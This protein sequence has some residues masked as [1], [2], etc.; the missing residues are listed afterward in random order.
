MVCSQIAA[1]QGTD[2]NAIRLEKGRSLQALLDGFRSRGL[3]SEG[4]TQRHLYAT[5]WHALDALTADGLGVIVLGGC[6]QV[7]R[8]LMISKR[9][10]GKW[11]LAMA[12]QRASRAL[13]PL[14][15]LEEVLALAQV[16]ARTELVP[17]VWLLTPQANPTAQPARMGSWGL[18]RTARMEGSLTLRCMDASVTTAFSC[19]PDVETEAVCHRHRRLVPRLKIAPP[20]ADGFVQHFGG[21]HIVTGGTGGLGLLTGRWLAACG[22]R[23]LVLASRSGE[24]GSNTVGEMQILQASEGTQMR[25]E[26]CDSG[27][28]AH[29]IRL[30]R[31]S[32]LNGSCFHGVWHAAGVIADGVLSK[33]DILALAHVYTAK[34]HGSWNLHAACTA[35]NLRVFALFSSVAALLGTV[36]QA[37]YAA[38]NACLDALAPYRRMRSAVATSVQ[39]GAWA[40]VGMA[41]RGA[42]SE[43][44]TVLEAASGFARIKLAQGLRVLGT[45]VRLGASPVLALVPVTWSRILGSGEESPAFL[46]AFQRRRAGADVVQGATAAQTILSLE[47]VLEMVRHTAGKE[48]NADAPLM[49]SGVDSLGAVELRNQ[50]QTA[51]G[52]SLPSTLVFDF[53]S[54]RQVALHIQNS[55]LVAP[56]FEPVTTAPALG[57]HLDTQNNVDITG[58]NIE[59]AAGVGCLRSLRAKSA[60]GLDLLGQIPA[61]RWDAKQAA[62]SMRGLPPEVSSRMRHAGFLVNAELF[63]QNFY[64][65]SKAEA[66]AMDPQQRQLLER[67]YVA[68]H[69]GGST[70]STLLGSV[71]A[72]NVGQWASEFGSVLVRTPAGRSVYASTGYT[73]SVTCGRVSFA[74]GMQGPCCSFD[75]ACSASLVAN[76]SSM[77]ALQKM[78]C[79]EALSAGVNMITDPATMGYNAIA[80]FTSITGRSHTFDARAD[81]Y[82]R[83]EAVGAMVCTLLAASQV[84]VVG[85]AIRQDGRSASLTAPNGQAQQGVLK[86][87]YTDASQQATKVAM[88]EAHG[89]GTALGDPIE[90]GAVAAV[91]LSLRTDQ[92]ASL[93]TGSLKANA[94]HCEPGAGLA[95]ASKLIVHLN[96]LAVPPNA[97]LRVLNPH[98]GG[99]L[100]GLACA[101]PTQATALQNVPL[102]GGVSSFGYAGTIAHVVI[103]TSSDGEMAA[104]ARE[105][106]PMA[107]AIMDVEMRDPYYRRRFSWSDVP[108]PFLMQPSSTDGATVFQ[109]TAGLLHELVADHA[110]QGR[111]IFPAAGYLELSRAAT[112]SALRGVFFLQPLTVEAPDLLVECAV[113]DAR[114]EV[115]SGEGETQAIHCS[116]AL[117]MFNGWSR[118]EQASMRVRSCS[119]A[120]CTGALYDK[121]D[122]VGLQY[123]PGYRTL[124][125]AWVG[126]SGAA[127]ARL[128]ERWTRNGALVHP[129]DLDDALKI[130]VAVAASGGGTSLPF[131]VDNARLQGTHGVLWAV[132]HT[133]H[134]ARAILLPRMAERSLR[135]GSQ[136]VARESMEAVSVR[137]GALLAP[138]AQLDDFKTRALRLEAPTQ[139]HLY[140]TE[141]RTLDATDGIA[142]SPMLMIS[143]DLAGITG[144]RRVVGRERLESGLVASLAVVAQRVSPVPLSTLEVALALAQ[145]QAALAYA[146][147]VWLLTR[148][149]PP[150]ESAMHAGSWG[151]MRAVRAEASLPLCCSVATTLSAFKRCASLTEP[152]VV[153][154]VRG[155][156]TPRLQTAAPTLSGLM[157]LHFHSRGAISNLFLESLPPPTSLREAEVRLEVRAVG[158]NFRDVLNVLGEYP[159]DPG[160]P[161]GDA[162]GFVSEVEFSTGLHAIGDTVFGLAHAPLASLA[163][164]AAP[165]LARKPSVLVLQAACTLPVTWSTTHM[166]LERAGLRAGRSIIVQAAVGGVGLKA[167]EYAQWLSAVAVGTAGR[168]HKHAPLRMSGV[169]ALGSSRNGAAFAAGITGLLKASRSHALL[170]SLSLDFIAA[171]FAALGEGGAFGE[172]GKR[173]IWASQRR[174]AAAAH[175]TYCAI[176]LDAD[177]AQ[178][179]M[180]MHGV[181]QKLAVRADTS[182][183]TSLP[184][185]SFDM[186]VQHELAF[187]TLQGGL[188]TGKIVV[189]VAKYRPAGAS[190]GHVV[191]GGT[192][193]LGLLTARWIG[194]CGAKQLSL[195]SRSGALA[196]G[197]SSEWSVLANVADV[198]LQQ[199]DTSEDAHVRRLV[200]KT[201]ATLTGVWHAAGVLAD[202]MLPKQDARSLAVVH[203]PKAHGVQSLHGAYSAI[204]LR[205][206]V[207][208][209]SVTALLGGSGQANYSAANA[210]LDALASH[211]RMHSAAAVSVQ[212]GAWAEMGMAARGAASER[213]AAMEAASG[214]ARIGLAQ[215]L[216]ALDV[217]T[218]HKSPMVL[219][220]VPISWTRFLGGSTAVPAF[221]LTFAPPK[222][223]EA[224]AVRDGLSSASCVV[225]LESV[226]EMVQR[227]AGGAVDADAPLM[228]SGVD[229]LGAVELRNQL[230]G[231]AG[232]SLPSTLVFDH[233]TARQLG[234]VVQPEQGTPSVGMKAPSLGSALSAAAADVAIGGLTALVAAGASSARMASN[235]VACGSDMITEVPATRW[236]LHPHPGLPEPIASRIRH[237]GFVRDAELVDNAAFATSPAEA[238][239]MDPCQ[240]LLLERSY[241]ALHDA[242]LD[243][244]ALTGSLVGVFL[245]YAATE[246]GSIIA[247]SP[248]GGSVYAAT[249]ASVSIA[250]GRLSYALGLH[251]PC[252]S[253]DTACSAA[254]TASHAALRA[255]QLD[256][257]ASCL[258]MGATLFFAPAISTA[259]AV[260]GMTSAQGRSRTFDARADGYARGEACGGVAL[261]GDGESHSVSL[262]GA[263]VRQDGRSASLT[264][265][266]GQAQQGVLVAALE[267]AQTSV[268]MLAQNEA[269][270]TGTKLGD[271][272]EASSLMGAVLSSRDEPL[273]VG[274]VKANIGHAEPAAGM[275]GLLKLALGLRHGDAGP[276]AHLRVRNP[277]V[278]DALSEAPVILQNQLTSSAADSRAGGVSS[279]GYSG[280][281]VHVLMSERGGLSHAKTE[282]EIAIPR[283]ALC[284]RRRLF[285]WRDHESDQSSVNVQYSST[286][287]PLSD[288]TVPAAKCLVLHTATPVHQPSK[289]KAPSVTSKNHADLCIIGGGL[290]GFIIARDSASCGFSSIVLEMED[291]I[292]GVWAKNDYPGL[293]LQHSGAAYRC[294]SLA[295]TWQREGQGRE[296][297]LYAPRA[298]EILTY[299]K[300]M[301]EHELIAVRL[302][303]AYQSHH[304]SSQHLY[305]V[306]TNKAPV[307]ARGVVIATG[308]NETT[309]GS[310][311]WPI[312]RS[313]ITNGAFVMHSSGLTQG[314][315]SFDTATTKY[316]VGSSKAAIDALEWMDPEDE[317]LV[318][319]HRGH[320]IFHNRNWIDSIWKS[321]EPF[322]P[323]EVSRLL[324][325][326]HYLK[327]QQFDAAFGGMLK[328]GIAI[329][330]GL[331]L[332]T[333]PWLRGGFESNDSL[334]HARRFLPRQVIIS[335]L[336]IHEGV[337][338][339]CCSDGRVISVG[340]TDAVIMCTGQRSKSG[341]EASYK[342]RAELNKDGVFHVYA[343]HR[344]L[345]VQNVL[346]PSRHA[347]P[348]LSTVCARRCTFSNISPTSG[349]YM[350]FCVVSFL[351]GTPT[352]YTDGRLAAALEKVAKHMEVVRDRTAWGRFW[353]EQ[354]AT[355]MDAAPLLLDHAKIE[356]ASLEQHYRWFGE[357]YG[358]DLN[359]ESVFSLF[360]TEQNPESALPAADSSTVL[361]LD[362]ARGMDGS[363]G[364]VHAMVCLA[365]ALTS[366][367]TPTQ[368]LVLTCGAQSPVPAAAG[369]GVGGVAHSGVWG[370]ARTLRLELPGLR[371]RNADVMGRNAALTVSV[372]ASE[373]E[374]EV[375]CANGTCHAARLCHHGMDITHSSS[376]LGGTWMLTG[377]LGGLSLRAAALLAT[378]NASR[379]VL[380]SRSGRVVREGQ[381]LA[382][383]LRDLGLTAVLV[384]CDS[385]DPVQST[386]M[387][388]ST[389]ARGVLHAAGLTDDQLILQ[390][391]TSAVATVFASKAQAAARL[392]D[393]SAQTAIDAL[394]L[395]SSFAAMFGGLGVGNYAA[396]N[397]VLDSLAMSRQ[398]RGLTACSLQPLNVS[399][400]GM[401]QALNDVGK[402]ARSWSL[403][404][405][406][407]AT[408]L[409]GLLAGG[410]GVHLPLPRDMARM[411]AEGDASTW[412]Q[413]MAQSRMTEVAP[414]GVASAP[415]TVAE[416]ASMTLATT[417]WRHHAASIV[418]RELRELVGSTATF[419]VDTTLMDAGL[420][421]LGATE[422]SSRLRELTG[423]ELSPTI[424]FEQPTPRAVVTHLLEQVGTVAVMESV[425]PA[426]IRVTAAGS[427]LSLAGLAGRWPG[428]CN[429]DTTRW[430][431]QGSCGNAMGR[432]PRTRWVLEETVDVNVLSASQASC[433]RH[434]GF[435]AGSQCFDARAFGIS[436]AEASAMDPQQRLLLE[437]GYASL[438]GSSHRRM[439]LM[440]G[441][442]GVLLGIERPDWALAQPPSARGS[443]F[444]ATGDNVSAAAGRVSFVLGLQGPCS[445]VDTACSSSLVAVHW[446]SHA[447]TC[448][449]CA[450]VLTLA[451]GLKLVP[452]F[453][454]GAAAAGMLSMDGR[455]KTLDAGANGYA[456][457]EAVG[458]FLLLQDSRALQLSGSAVRQDG[459]SAS[460]TAPNGS[461]Q[462]TLLSTAHTRTGIEPANLGRVELHGTGTALGDPTEAGSLGGVHGQRTTPLVVGA[463]KA[464]LGHSEAPSGQVGLL[465]VWQAIIAKATSANAKLRSI[466]PLIRE[467]LGLRSEWFVLST[468]GATSTSASGLSAFGYSGTIAYTVL[469]PT[470]DDAILLPSPRY[471]RQAFAW[472]DDAY[473]ATEPM[474]LPPGPTSKKETRHWHYRIS[475]SCV[476]D[477]F[478]TSPKG[479]TLLAVGGGP[480]IFSSWGDTV[481]Q[482]PEVAKG[483]LEG[484][485][486]HAVILTASLQ[487]DA[488]ANLAE[489]RVVDTALRLLQEQAALHTA[490]PV[491]LATRATQPLSQ[492]VA[493]SHSGLW[494]LAR[495]CRLEHMTLPAWCVDVR[496]DERC[497]NAVIRQ[498]TL[499]LPHGS[500]QALQLSASVEPEAACASDTLY[501]PRLV[502]PPRE[503][504]ATLEIAFMMVCSLLDTHTSRATS[505]LDMVRL[506]RAYALLETLCQQYLR[507][508]LDALS[509]SEVP[510]WHH[511]LV[512]AWCSNV[513]QLSPSEPTIAPADV[514][515]AHSDL[516]AEVHL[517][518]RC[519]S[520]FADA[521]SGT[522]AYQ[523]LLF[524]GGSMEAV[525]PVYEKAVGQSF[526]NTCV[527]AAVEAVLVLTGERR[528]VMLEVGAGTG[529]TASSILPVVKSVCDRYV[530]TDVSKAFMR[531]ARARFADF[532]FLECALL[533]IDADP[534]LQGFAPHEHDVIIST[535]CLHATPF[536]R[537]TL[538]NCAELLCAGG[539]IIVNEVLATASFAQMTFGMTDGW[540]LFAEV[541]DPE[542]IGQ[543]S[544]LLSWR[545]WEAL[546]IANGFCNACSIQGDTFL[547]NQAVMLAQTFAPAGNETLMAFGDGAHFLSGGLGGLG[548]LTARLLVEQGALQIFLSSGSNRVVAGSEAD[549]AWLAACDAD[550]R[551]VECDAAD[552]GSVRAV[553]RRLRGDGLL[554]LDGVFNTAHAL[555]EAALA[556]QHVLNFRSTYGPKVHSATAMHNTFM[557]A[558]L[559][560][561]NLFSSSAGLMGSPGQASHSA[562]TAWAITMA[563]RRSQIG[564]CGSSSAVDTDAFGG[565][566]WS[567][568]PMHVTNLRG[569]LHMQAAFTLTLDTPIDFFWA[570]HGMFTPWTANGCSKDV[571]PMT[572]TTSKEQLTSSTVA[573]C[574]GGAQVLQKVLQIAQTMTSG[575]LDADMPLVDAGID[576]ISAVELRNQVSVLSSEPALP[577]TLVF[578]HPTARGLSLFLSGESDRPE[579]SIVPGA[580]SYEGNSSVLRGA[581]A[582]LPNN[583]L[584]NTAIW[585]LAAASYDAISEV[586]FHRKWE[587]HL[588]EDEVRTRMQYAGFLVTTELFDNC[589]FAVSLVETR[590]MD[591]S[592]RLLLD[593]G[594]TALHSSGLCRSSLMDSVT[595]VFV[596]IS[597]SHFLDCLDMS[598][599]SGVYIGSGSALAIASGRLS[600]VLGMQ[601][602]CVSLDT[603]CSGGLVACHGALSALKFSE[604]PTALAGGVNMMLTPSASHVFAVAGMTSPHG[605]CHTFDQRADGYTRAEACSTAALSNG[606]DG[607]SQC[608]LRGSAVRQDG[609]SASLTAPNGQAQRTLINVTTSAAGLSPSD[610]SCVEAHGTGTAL[611]DP[612]EMGAIAASLCASN[613]HQIA[614]SSIKSNV[615]HTE[616]AAGLTG[617]LKL[618]VLEARREVASNAQLRAL[619]RHVT[620][621]LQRARCSLPVQHSRSLADE[622]ATGGVS[623][624]GWSGTIA[625]LLV[626]TT[627]KN[628]SSCELTCASMTMPSHIVEFHRRLA[629]WQRPV[630]P[631]LQSRH[632]TTPDDVVV[633]FSSPARGGLT[634]VV[635]D[636]VILGQTTFPAAGYIEMAC[637]CVA[638]ASQKTRELASVRNLFFLQPLQ[639]SAASDVDVTCT[640]RTDGVVQI[641]S[642][643]AGSGDA[644]THCSGEQDSEQQVS[645]LPDLI[646]SRG[647]SA[648]P[649]DVEAF[650]YVFHFA[651]SNYGPAFQALDHIWTADNATRESLACLKPRITRQG[652]C[653]HP[654]DLDGALQLASW[655]AA[656]SGSAQG[657]AR[658]PFAV[659]AATLHSSSATR[660]LTVCMSFCDGSHACSRATR[661]LTQWC[662]PLLAGCGAP[663]R[664]CN[665]G[666]IGCVR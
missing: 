175:T 219:G 12:T 216:A 94:G 39:W 442:S 653:V 248:A 407:Y 137:L 460:L 276:N 70:K 458:A 621:P 333:Q 221:L 370:L 466:N 188:N 62:H 524:P 596:A 533:N 550:V 411:A 575:S 154:H 283:K 658:L 475:W 537:N 73:C 503:Q 558:S 120:A 582:C 441:D 298:R 41:A 40:E 566:V 341:G 20:P 29:V 367:K 281:I 579:L 38:A 440:S 570:R 519:G 84:C 424:V 284:F 14:I 225:S 186:E 285:F 437:F 525:L 473:I 170:N 10:T 571:T 625:H 584:S 168:P 177:M 162:A 87:A 233:P 25:I 65:I 183:I 292:G 53:P 5:E 605:R 295:P 127:S 238:T 205:A 534:R 508:A 403:G 523:E 599:V 421:S 297:V 110:V 156:C 342:R 450:D 417:E 48:V 353:A 241:T 3:R 650:Y 237:G 529:G 366:S 666:A 150:S 365:Q 250:S 404:I 400:M 644:H 273:A 55:Q 259:F 56:S 71:V 125:Q 100:G 559:R 231:A 472:Y 142:A 608:C 665:G 587:L 198:S 112:D 202:C 467:R 616:S 277:H 169:E 557:C 104:L 493:A 359:V 85:S 49:E 444:A 182:V 78:E 479:L 329:H 481:I 115:R 655:G 471:R 446:A 88:L 636:H 197:T 396:A 451:I 623:S 77:R 124:T 610:Y 269:H 618:F 102:T 648:R 286:F 485:R 517:A 431:L 302:G 189:R 251:G 642:S 242:S 552:E 305:Q 51:A 117:S 448:G 326:N 592:Q 263:A 614:V 232:I 639:L 445:S 406:Q 261:R 190:G 313:Q 334:A 249:G 569:S 296:D 364:G 429:K 165:L 607:Q 426:G 319:A 657:E 649:L 498:H 311:Y 278:G 468:Q 600:Y 235:I 90:A 378:C 46:S 264:A 58:L 140:V 220:M 629:A 464:N 116:G 148:G 208:F 13:Q 398:S 397:T 218:L 200:G 646:V 80:G 239:A 576:S 578:D 631:M 267:D 97:Q 101:L 111:V 632:V 376:T 246:F 15:L 455:C 79:G 363:L 68:F 171:S 323:D 331:P 530:F 280:T 229:S 272:I 507:D 585:C 553:V 217:A 439:T 548:M 391:A 637:A 377:G 304:R 67:G 18:A 215:G 240:R 230:Q 390:M 542:R 345:P 89:T 211:R 291:A 105:A 159:G 179:P 318:W 474:S 382:E 490:L 362:H 432:V 320:V 274:G 132:R 126:V 588:Y 459:R 191:T 152:E 22:A 567:V 129:A 619:N 247:A 512:V 496:D 564:L 95:G 86:A 236:D 535:N 187:R 611:G 420:N 308:V 394:V 539:W 380:S 430:E 335:S 454:L 7:S 195:A 470:V 546:L 399:N 540:W 185:Q 309:A 294:L 425:V 405:E 348:R 628:E 476:S 651:G 262:L 547:R 337:L 138:Q 131:A 572:A 656:E 178:A 60:C 516:W 617:L 24:L 645:Q 151:L 604:A 660:Q 497:M 210:H 253:Y 63:D 146:P 634:T 123:G 92:L 268:G 6:K 603:A 66:S 153:L 181:L 256:E 324:T 505:A 8:E 310:P 172:I 383:R 204:S 593:R 98:V 463:A 384:A 627:Y 93:D 325:G 30:A 500:V 243:R 515:A 580:N 122:A 652:T 560:I 224:V 583:A 45:A 82:A 113:A 161:G 106:E 501:V 504:P 42:A 495:A 254:L 19:G 622:T 369:A 395:Y 447:V 303:T 136:A 317:R 99:V 234:S 255:L 75:T 526:Y 336:R 433:V 57:A 349:L 166:S 664:R 355:Q 654:A 416:Q 409:S 96:G 244:A 196:R 145:A 601:G 401:A 21:G 414:Q 176:A 290:V 551:R 387:C 419:D 606:A 536:M 482:E 28:V 371:T 544:P 163:C 192:G 199:C 149:A 306:T 16:Q 76:H 226:L 386:S 643:A 521:M 477:D 638:A 59:L 213:M 461:A 37:N 4:P 393:S 193:G 322:P 301:A 375:A 343:S 408:C 531:K 499:Q 31:A 203:A 443:V 81:G 522:M 589:F 164:A 270:G 344:T 103:V 332:A 133:P 135:V 279:F 207:L 381:G 555:A 339:M 358:R 418:Q 2:K 453:T 480:P 647:K 139:R 144:K 597:Q 194:Q 316:V 108:H 9:H 180:W 282:S 271:P 486:W 36:G 574:P 17:T 368:L 257:C 435:V 428:G 491:W 462:R 434:S 121:F 661:K 422:F 436:P 591:P 538:R 595:G 143:T 586:P 109:S 356:A 61:L 258:V 212:W 581:G 662:L 184:L 502:A 590:A 573:T 357:W 423:V 514:R 23:C 511:K 174:V 330:V 373:V 340:A 72:V 44:M 518:E 565:A 64:G 509:R 50:L 275:T 119:R 35:A 438:H 506:L 315:A 602:P 568:N 635:A 34:A 114:F 457:S 577:S 478:P 541:Q 594:Y 206:C 245:G 209:S 160:P 563:K 613:E 32:C 452:H 118:V 173:S 641:A 513:K 266:N 347:R 107:G 293:G 1:P 54:A 252:V 352:A 487:E 626:Q 489:L 157:R 456:R 128:R 630:H 158:L 361:L 155:A 561:F 554:K 520:R 372:L 624:F 488:S 389:Q 27:D 659:D 299:I 351:K 147:S 167:I 379:L 532:P 289:L 91:F 265:P 494:G 663:G 288:A 410:R 33:Q 543:D 469:C 449:E 492:V 527:E 83:G 141:W 510:V 47:S 338:Q 556:N 260:A 300:K 640:L 412:K 223:I 598:T 214:F 307:F 620:I 11:A 312:D 562:A 346:W 633:Y 228:E 549:W 392:H 52:S 354:G 484:V 413:I 314:K 615:A 328:D 227:T 43:R 287:R 465:R 612:Q 222:T 360:A 415:A 402:H 350:L 69:A 374:A 545:Q 321:A 483:M 385:S 327:N 528:M 201:M 427:S 388:S 130:S 609:K 74:L 134:P 26:R